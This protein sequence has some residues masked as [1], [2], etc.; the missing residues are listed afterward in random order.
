MH[1][2]LLD[3]LYEEKEIIITKSQGL[4]WNLIPFNPEA[5][6][7]IKE[8]FP[9]YTIIEIDGRIMRAKGDQHTLLNP[10]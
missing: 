6:E 3:I 1:L 5:F 8:Y 2:Y 10:N 7:L 9:D 4:L